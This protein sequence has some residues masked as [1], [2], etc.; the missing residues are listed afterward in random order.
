MAA[1]PGTV[2]RMSV[3]RSV[4]M[5]VD[6]GEKTWLTPRW[7]LDKLGPFD[8]DPCCPDGGMPWPTAARMI[9]KSED[10]LAKDWGGGPESF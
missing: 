4:R 9:S 8:L 7:L 1:L 10:S 5:N 6:S 3:G 2:L